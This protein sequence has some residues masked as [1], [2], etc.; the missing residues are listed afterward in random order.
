MKLTVVGC[1]GSFP[2]P[3]SPAS[4]YLVEADGQRIL[5][6]LGSGALGHL[7]RH[8]DIYAVRAV[9]LS[10]LHPDHCFD[11]AGLFVAR[12]YHP[13]GVTGRISVYGPVGVA[14]RMAGA[15]DGDRPDALEEQFE[16]VEWAEGTPRQ[17]G[18]FQVT[19]ARVA[20]PRQCFAIRVEH[21]GR[22]LVYSGDTGPC[23]ALVDLARGADLLLCEAS[24]VEGSDNPP[25]Q[26]LTGA[27]AGEHAER[28]GVPR[29]VV[30]HVPP[31]YDGPHALDEA[32]STF[33]GELH[34][35]RPGAS[36]DV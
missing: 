27:Q 34:L 1:S 19:V 22:S 6:D 29:L 33:H 14:A 5:L 23:Q 3:D 28:A 31:W 21:D 36:Y 7:A 32:R 30:T 18:P 15:Y 17:I 25:D 4:C 12:H 35:A 9:L 24:Y 13:G 2:G 10:H 16:Y 8:T 20:H 11:L 26:H